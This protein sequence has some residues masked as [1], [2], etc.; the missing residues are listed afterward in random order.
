VVAAYDTSNNPIASTTCYVGQP[1]PCNV[2]AEAQKQIAQFTGNWNA[3]YIGGDS[4]TC[5]IVVAS[6]GAVA[7]SRCTSNATGAFT[8]SGVLTPDP[9]NPNQGTFKGTAS[10]GATYTGTFVLSVNG[11]STTGSVTG[12]TWTNTGVGTSGTWDASYP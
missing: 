8:I 2:T 9:N 3:S 5:T 6:T 12:G 11:S 1:T 4:G 7:Q 10:T